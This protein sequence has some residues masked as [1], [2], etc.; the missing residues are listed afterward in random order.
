MEQKLKILHL[1]DQQSDSELI[2][3]QLKQANI[4][5][6]NITVDTKEEFIS[7][8]QKFTPDIILADHSV[9]SFNS[10]EALKIV[11]EN[12]LQIPFLLVTTAVSESLVDEIRNEG[13]NGFILKD[14]L[15]TLPEAITNAMDEVYLK[16]QN[17]PTTE[18]ILSEEKSY[19]LSMLEEMDDYEYLAEILSIFL[20]ETPGELK[21]MQIAA[22]S[23]KYAVAAAKAHKL[24]SSSGLLEANKLT[25][26][27]QQIEAK[28]KA[29]DQ[30][31]ELK[32]LAEAAQQEY[33]KIETSLK[34]YLKNIPQN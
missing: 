24:K 6:E 9:T 12:N 30:G 29:E 28:A 11:K 25:L 33:S 7:A 34:S 5:F 8:L 18:V 17:Y 26:I 32:G 22:S 1:E 10:L 27:L 23:K 20:T 19:D 21:E 4:Q 14:N 3:M 13:G 31:N 16:K 15:D 2:N